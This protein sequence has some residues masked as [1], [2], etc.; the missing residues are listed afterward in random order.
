MMRQLQRRPH[1]ISAVLLDSEPVSL[2]LGWERRAEAYAQR[3]V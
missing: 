1:A 2:F 3:K